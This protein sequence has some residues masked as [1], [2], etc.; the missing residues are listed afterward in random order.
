MDISKTESVTE[1]NRTSLDKYQEFDRDDASSIRSEALGDDLPPGYY[2]SPRFL[3][4]LA[5]S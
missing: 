2:Y 4:A 1:F 3:G 5:V